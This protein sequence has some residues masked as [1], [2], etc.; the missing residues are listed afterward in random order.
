MIVNRKVNVRS[1]NHPKFNH[2]QADIILQSKPDVYMRGEAKHMTVSAYLLEETA[3]EGNRTFRPRT[4]QLFTTLYRFRR[5]DLRKKSPVLADTLEAAPD[6]EKHLIDG[7]PVLQ[8]QHTDV[9]YNLIFGFFSDDIDDFPSLR[10]VDTE[11]LCGLWDLSIFLETIYIQS[12][13]ELAIA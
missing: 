6:S 3:E 2:P 1:S 12:H 8:L 9:L 7:L 4:G 10:N 13:C 5:E 11:T